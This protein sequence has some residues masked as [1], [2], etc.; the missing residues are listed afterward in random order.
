MILIVLKAVQQ[1]GLALQFASENLQNDTE[2]F[3]EAIRQNRLALE[4][5]D[6]TF[7]YY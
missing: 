7:P 3:R 6:K 5:I 2:I 4:F 1:N